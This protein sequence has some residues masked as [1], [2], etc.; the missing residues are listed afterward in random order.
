[1]TA[2]VYGVQ[3]SSLA[4]PGQRPGVDVPV[5]SEVSMQI[6]CTPPTRQEG[7]GVQHSSLAG[8]GQNPGVE[9]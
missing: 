1:M 6:P 7:G 9:V 2:R 8:P 3:H 5:Q 4:G